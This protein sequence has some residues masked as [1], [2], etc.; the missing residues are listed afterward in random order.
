MT[1]QGGSSN[2]G[3]IFKI[4]PD[5]TGFQLLHSFVSA[6]V[7]GQK[8]I[9]SL[10]QS[11]SVL[12]GMAASEETSYGGTVFKLNNDGSGFQ[13]LRYLAGSD[14]M[15]PYDTLTQSG[16]TLFGMCTYGGSASG[17]SGGGTIFR[18]G[19]DGSGFQLLHTFYSGSSDGGAPHGSLVQSG[20]ILY[21]MTLY[22]GSSDMGTI[23]KINSDGT[24]FQLLHTFTGG[25]G[26]WPCSGKLVLSG[27]MLYGMVRNGGAGDNG[28]IFKINTNGS[29]FQI[30][31][32]FT[33]GSNGQWPFGQPIQSDETL[34]GMTSSGG[35]NGYGTIFKVDTSGTGFQILHD[36]AGE[37]NDGA[38]PMG[39]LLLSGLTLYGMT[40]EGGSN[41]K[42]VIFALDIPVN[43]V[44][45]PSSDL[46]GDCKVDFQDFAVLAS[47]WLDCGLEPP[48]AC[49]Q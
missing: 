5:G 40:T 39:S 30:L 10:I 21:G 35:S 9:G 26:K 28:I 38:R 15:W 18:I 45:P 44:N 36:F 24:G 25:N 1:W 23:F 42:G 43:C 20:S 19:T 8:P 4:N 3:T 17:Y 47:E 14:G 33:G 2:N 49:N 27:S 46:N 16:P 12:Y 11:G 37:A 29:G 6:T 7:D 32:T 31:H 41:N 34:Y 22:G 48:S 13:V